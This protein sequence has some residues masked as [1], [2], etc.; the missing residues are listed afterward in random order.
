MEIMSYAGDLDPTETHLLLSEDPTAVLVDCR[1]TAEWSYVGA[2]DLTDLGKQ[3][4]FIEWNRFPT[5]EVNLDFVSQLEEA[6]IDRSQPV[7]F[8]CRS[9][10][11]SKA[12]A[13]AAT[14]A[15]FTAA[16]NVAKGFEGPADERGHRGTRA[17]WKVAGLPWKQP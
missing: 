4:V 14:A 1:T 12:A 2:P 3:V 5:G 15:G 16:Y 10:V 9:G 11:R 6:G 7:A 8:L 17:G 13:S